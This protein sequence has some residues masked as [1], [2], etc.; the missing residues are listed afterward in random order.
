MQLKSDYF[1][2]LKAENSNNKNRKDKK[3][4]VGFGLLSSAGQAA[5]NTI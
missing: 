5:N 3:T 2:A 1:P 4:M